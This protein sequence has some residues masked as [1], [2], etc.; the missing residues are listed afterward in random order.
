MWMVMGVRGVCGG[1]DGCVCVWMVMGSWGVYVVVVMGVC[2][3]MGDGVGRVMS[4][5]VVMWWVG[6]GVMGGLGVHVCRCVHVLE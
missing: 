1:G 5:C 4:V 2:V 3:W 6:G